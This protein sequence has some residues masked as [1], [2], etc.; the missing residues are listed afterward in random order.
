[1]MVER[2]LEVRE[3][4]EEEFGVRKEVGLGNGV[5]EE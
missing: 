5:G 2:V 3:D 4:I 1:M